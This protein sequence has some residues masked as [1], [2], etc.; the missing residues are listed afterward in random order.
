MVGDGRTLCTL[1]SGDGGIFIVHTYDVSSG[2]TSSSGTLESGDHPHLWKAD[3]TFRVMTTARGRYPDNDTIDVFKVE[4]TLT[5]IESFDFPPSSHSEAKITSF[6]PT[7]H[8]VSISDGNTLYVFDIRNSERLL[9]ETGNFV[10]HCFS[11]RGGY[12]AASQESSVH[13]WSYISGSYSLSK[14]LQRQG[15]SNSP[16]RISSTCSSMLSHSGNTLQVWRSDGY[17]TTPKQHYVGLSRSGTHAATA[18]EKGIVKIIDLLTQTPLQSIDTGVWWIKGLVLT[19]NVLLVAGFA[20]LRAWLLTEEGVVDGVVGGRRVDSSDSI[21]TISQSRF[22][23]TFRVEGQVGVI[24]LGEDVLHFYHTETGEVLDPTQAPR[25][26]SSRWYHFFEPLQGRDYLYFHNLSQCDTPPEDSWQISRAAVR[27]GWVKDP[28]G[29]HRLWIPAE[30]RE[31]WDSADWREDVTT[32][33]SYLGG[34]P[35]IIKF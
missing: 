5:K 33:F 27:E 35:V 32:Q 23:W 34:R 8:H 10:S 30:W 2:T 12:F 3:G 7:A 19:G 21:W 22:P 9:A 29:R 25:H 15:W 4:S 16:L 26:F 13:L 28:E 18:D 17:S 24:N 6:S 11:T 20:D 1:N 14:K 31:E